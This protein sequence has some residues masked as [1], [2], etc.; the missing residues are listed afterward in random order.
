MQYEA[1]WK[2]TGDVVD[3]REL[4]SE[5][6]KAWRGYVV[7]VAV[8][9]ATLEVQVSEAEFKSLGVGEHVQLAGRFERRS[10]N[11]LQL[12]VTALRRDGKAVAA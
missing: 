2:I 12:I 4:T 3:R 9:G 5:K 10:D 1:S 6:N 8:V 11:V 7:K